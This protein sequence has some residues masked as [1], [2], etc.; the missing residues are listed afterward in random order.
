MAIEIRRKSRSAGPSAK[1]IVTRIRSEVVPVLD[2][3]R[4]NAAAGGKERAELEFQVLSAVRKIRLNLAPVLSR[5][6]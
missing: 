2:E 6:K 3:L 4:R 5:N 1:R